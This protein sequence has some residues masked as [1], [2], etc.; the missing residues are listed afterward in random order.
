MNAEIHAQRPV[1]QVDSLQVSYSKHIVLNEI[2][3]DVYRGE[4]LTL[5]GRS[6]S[7]KTTLLKTI[8]GL[9]KP[10]NGKIILDNEYNSQDIGMVFQS[11]SLFPHLTV[12]ENIA[13]GLKARKKTRQC[14][15]E[16][17]I[18]YS[19]F[20]HVDSELKKYPWQLSGGQQ[21][22]V[23]MARA[24]VL[25]P[26][27]LLMDEPFS[28]IDDRN[29]ASCRE[30]IREIRD[31]KNSA[32]VI[33]THIIEDAL[34]LSDRI[35]ILEDGEIK[36]IDKVKTMVSAPRAQTA[37]ALGLFDLISDDLKQAMGVDK[38]IRCY[39]KYS[40]VRPIDNYSDPHGSLL[41]E[42]I[43]KHYS[44]SGNLYLVAEILGL[45]YMGHYLIIDYKTH[46]GE[47]RGIAPEH[48]I[49]ELNIGHEVLLQLRSSDIVYES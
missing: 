45:Q 4:I 32:I 41:K 46:L 6:G 29:R 49:N 25:D 16:K 12:E 39:Y 48:L 18:E 37:E 26:V 21:Q 42:T 1:I 15:K 9:I 5:L 43:A 27:V 40:D 7:G 8:A 31:K 13:Y 17:V 36:Q 44:Y 20:L 24:M 35:L 3:F 2:S 33:A 34:S 38:K 10:V 47:L 30:M 19:G 28:N 22:R 14:I 11:Y 23:A